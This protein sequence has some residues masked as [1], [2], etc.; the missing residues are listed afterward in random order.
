[1]LDI[2][3]CCAAAGRCRGRLTR[4][5]CRD[6]ATVVAATNL[7]APSLLLF[8]GDTERPAIPL[9]GVA[10]AEISCCCLS[11]SRFLRNSSDSSFF[12]IQNS[13]TYS[14]VI[15]SILALPPRLGSMS[16][17]RCIFSRIKRL[18]SSDDI[19]R[20]V[21]D[22]E[23]L[24]ASRENADML[25]V[26]LTAPATAPLG[27]LG[28]AEE[29]R[30]TGAPLAEAVLFG[31]EKRLSLARS[32]LFRLLDSVITCS[33]CHKRRLFT[34]SEGGETKKKKVSAARRKRSKA[35]TK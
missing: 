7:L 26:V 17:S 34:V 1:M 10:T 27:F 29:P 19:D 2:V 3:G 22:V 14:G 35:L 21:I 31:N 16:G 32:I 23:V 11:R 12:F 18:A 9:A 28:S 8:T 15:L 20:F 25:F 4:K 5:G 13:C 6:G 24:L 33:S 30:E